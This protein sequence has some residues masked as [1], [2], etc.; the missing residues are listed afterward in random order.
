MKPPW[1]RRTLTRTSH[2]PAHN[3][4]LLVPC[5]HVLRY[6]IVVL[7]CCVQ[8]PDCSNWAKNCLQPI[9]RCVEH[10]IKLL[11][12]TIEI[13]T[14]AVQNDDGAD[15]VVQASE[16][17]K[18]IRQR[19]RGAAIHKRAGVLAGTDYE[20]AIENA[21]LRKLMVTAAVAIQLMYRGR[22]AREKVAALRAARSKAHEAADKDGDGKLDFKE[23]CAFV[24]SREPSE[25]LT[26]KELRARFE[27]LDADGSGTV[28]ISEYV[29]S[30][31]ATI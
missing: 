6:E 13:N 31:H 29:A 30:R 12:R 21:A 20:T 24:K 7:A 11:V 23:F 5:N 16:A 14:S 19:T 3:L 2:P 17:A 26:E 10:L 15:G 22:A 8:D 27:L 25:E 4:Q 18:F 9:W 28:D 1:H